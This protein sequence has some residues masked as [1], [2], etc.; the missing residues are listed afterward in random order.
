MNVDPTTRQSGLL[1]ETEPGGVSTSPGSAFAEQLWSRFRARR[2]RRRLALA[3]AAGTLLALGWTVD[4]RGPADSVRP[5]IPQRQLAALESEQRMLQQQ[6][7][8]LRTLAAETRP[9]IYL[10]GDESLDLVLSLPAADPG[11]RGDVRYAVDAGERS[12]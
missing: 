2:R 8:E 5:E 4:L 6:L 9:V 12:P 7:A 10:G 1:S 11:G 3:A